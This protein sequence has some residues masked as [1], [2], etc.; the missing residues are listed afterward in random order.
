MFDSSRIRK[1]EHHKNNYVY[2]TICNILPHTDTHKITY[3]QHTKHE[4]LKNAT[5]WS[6]IAHIP[7]L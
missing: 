5:K 2:V 4:A 3:S 7:R 6:Y 1:T